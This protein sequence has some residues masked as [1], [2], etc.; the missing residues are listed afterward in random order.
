MSVHCKKFTLQM[1]RYCSGTSEKS[2]N[3]AK[4]TRSL[5]RFKWK[6]DDITVAL[7]RSATER[8]TE[9]PQNRHITATKPPQNR[10]RS[11]TEPPQHATHASVS[12][13]LPRDE[14]DLRDIFGRYGSLRNVHL[15]PQRDAAHINFQRT[16]DAIEARK[17]LHEVKISGTFILVYFNQP[18]DVLR[19]DGIP[20]QLQKENARKLLVTEFSNFGKLVK[21]EIAH[22]KKTAFVYFEDEKDAI[23]AVQQLQEKT[24]D[25]WRWEIEF[26][27]VST[28]DCNFVTL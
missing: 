20:S 8:A 25:D 5:L 13:T 1:N 10:H 3:F 7:H 19:I 18:S 27:R 28:R 15:L 6:G 22:E 4:P 21:V 26:Y 12:S 9:P 23:E 2:E 14:R 17:R 24:F 16:Q 11:A